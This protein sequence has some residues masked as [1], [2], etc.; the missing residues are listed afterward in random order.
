MESIVGPECIKFGVQ[1]VLLLSFVKSSNFDRKII[2]EVPCVSN[3]LVLELLCFKDQHAQCTYRTMYRWLQELFGERWPKEAAPSLQSLTKSIERLKAKL[4][5]LRKQHTGIDKEATLETFLR[6]EYVFPSIGLCKGHVLH[7]SPAKP[8]S[9]QTTK[10]PVLSKLP[11]EQQRG[12]GQTRTYEEIQQRMYAVTR[13]AKKKIKR[14][15]ATIQEQKEK[16]TEQVK[17]INKYEGMESKVTKLKAKLNRV[18]HRASYWKSRGIVLKEGNTLKKK[19]LHDEIKTL[20]D[21]VSSIDFENAELNAELQDVLSTEIVTF[22]GGKYTD[23]IRACVYELL[24]LNVGV[25]NIAPTIR[26]VM[27]NLAQ[28]S[29]DRLPSHGLTCQ[30]IV[31]SLVAVQAQLGQKL[32]QTE[33]FNTLQT[34]GTS[35]FFQHYAAFDVSVSQ[36]DTYTLGLR[37]VFSG[38]SKDTLETLKEIL[39]DL[40]SVQFALGKDTVSGLIVSKIKNTMSDRHSAEKLFN[41]LLE[42]YRSEILPLV[43]ENWVEMNEIEKDQLTSMNNFF[44]GLHFIVGL[45]DATE[46]VLKQWENSSEDFQQ[47]SQQY[48]GSSGTQTLIRSACKAFHHRGSEQCG[49]SLLFRTYLKKEEISK[50]P[51]AQFIGNRF[52]V[53]FYDAAG[54]FYLRGHMQKFI[55]TVHGKEANRL[56]KAVLRDLKNPLYIAACRALGLLDKVITGPLWRKIQESSVSVL[57]MGD[58]YCELLEKCES[59]SMDAQ[60]FVEGSAIL[61]AANR[62]HVDDVWCKLIADDESNATTQEL[63]QLLFKAFSITIHRLLFDHLPDGKFHRTLIDATLIQ[64]TASVPTTNVAPERDFAILDRVL[65]EKPNASVIALE[66]LILFAHN[67]TSKWLDELGMDEREKI[68]KAAR[69][70]V[71]S[72]KEKFKKRQLEIQRR[73]EERLQSKQ[74]AIKLKAARELTEKEKLTEE[75]SKIGGLWMSKSDTVTGLANVKK[76]AEKVKLLKLQIKF[77]RKVLCQ[78]YSDLSV[79]KFSQNGKQL[80]VDQLEANLYKL[81]PTANVDAGMNSTTALSLDQVLIHPEKLVGHEIN[82]R[83]EVE[84]GEL[85]W[86]KGTVEKYNSR[87]N[88]FIVRYDG[89]ELPCSFPLLDDI[90]S[91]DLQLIVP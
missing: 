36:T 43:T 66:S 71:P 37:H 65:R 48:G 4:T 33:G 74:E 83:F 84:D 59:W 14:R 54:V 29:V 86:Y 9:N 7:F 19:E 81:L 85:V 15:D 91:G 57:D 67:K 89:E 35:K 28:K 68:F 26:C 18:N 52:N 47:Q 20:K 56:L 40:D 3:K 73:N 5:K 1:D 51:L 80:S 45:A 60:C 44:C 76:K 41:Q 31:E 10:Q 30:M 42:E 53:I 2:P 8:S 23:S 70:L 46:A 50:I 22:E 11:A 75:I 49:T 62:I 13:N 38:A 90:R 24:S 25:K 39:S 87:T 17:L 6:Q 12:S 58:V 69:S 27:K 88:E 78:T 61:E 82:H 72:F 34:D 55:E 32:S 63:L 64:E 16:I 77:R 79:F 21:K